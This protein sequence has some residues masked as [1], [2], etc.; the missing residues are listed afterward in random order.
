MQLGNEKQ[1]LINDGHYCVS[2][3]I[4]LGITTACHSQPTLAAYILLRKV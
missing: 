1:S 3:W 2:R 4:I